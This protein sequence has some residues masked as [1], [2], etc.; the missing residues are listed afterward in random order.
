MRVPALLLSALAVL[1]L[2]ACGRNPALSETNAIPDL[3]ALQ[4]R[5]FESLW[6]TVNE[7]YVYD[8]FHGLDWTSVRDRY[9]AMLHEEMETAEF[10]ALLEQMLAELPP[11]MV[12]LQSRQSRIEQA[13]AD[14]RSYEGIGSFVALRE[15][16]EPRILLL[17]VMPGS[18]AEA[19]GLES[20]DA[21]L[22]IDGQ[23][24]IGDAAE[25]IAL[26]RGPDG[27]TV[28]LTTRSPGEAPRDVI[29][30][31]GTISRLQNRLS[32]KGVGDS[33]IGYLLFPAATYESMLQDLVT[34]LQELQASGNLEA[35][36]LDLRIVSAGETWPV[37]SLLS[38]FTDGTV[39][40][41]YSRDGEDPIAITGVFDFIDTQEMQVALIVGPSTTGPAEIFAA[42]MKSE[43]KATIIGQA[44]SGEVESISSYFLPDGSRAMVATTSFRTR[45]G[46]EIGLAGLAP[47]VPV[48]LD[49]DEVTADDDP[50]IE[51][52]ERQLR[53]AL[54]SSG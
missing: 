41:F 20:H 22:A 21:I 37:G 2:V 34:G 16:P 19:A 36:I 30:T 40:E 11:G 15:E 43:G 25:A 29:V 9:R 3:Q 24:I 50:V 26:V 4:L 32:W 7:H 51:V 1:W 28:T 31:R 35:I 18:P 12:Q 8:D 10:N 14:D 49:W 6:T 17:S 42:I 27:S 38:L 23:P 48:G 5:T 53:A 33:G 52:A 45:T 44:T 46:L 13:A 54:E 39:G 47:D